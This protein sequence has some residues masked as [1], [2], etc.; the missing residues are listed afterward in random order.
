MWTF[1]IPS[2]AAS[3]VAPV[4]T[5]ATCGIR[6]TTPTTAGRLTFWYRLAALHE[7]SWYS[8][9]ATLWLYVALEKQDLVCYSCN[10][11][12]NNQWVL[13]L[14]VPTSVAHIS[15]FVISIRYGAREARCVRE[16]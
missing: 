12:S 14:H 7:A 2:S 5:A 4:A 8:P 9:H 13:V 3:L 16:R 15:L 1:A 6:H 11:A 10:D